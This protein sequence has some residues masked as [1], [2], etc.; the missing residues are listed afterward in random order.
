MDAREFK[1]GVQLVCG[2]KVVRHIFLRSISCMM[3]SRVAVSLVL[4]LWVGCREAH[5]FSGF[6]GG[7]TVWIRPAPDQ[8]RRSRPSAPNALRG[9]NAPGIVL[10]RAAL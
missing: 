8:A 10:R 4:A 1:I 5:H 9:G 3:I 7:P 6:G 2:V